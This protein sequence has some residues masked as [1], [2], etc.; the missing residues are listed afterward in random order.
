MISG[1]RA[2]S[3]VFGYE[4]DLLKAAGQVRD[5]NMHFKIYAPFASPQI[6]RISAGG[7]SPIRRFSL[8]GAIAGCFAGFGL[9][10]Y[11][12]LDWPLRTSAKAIASLPAYFV[13]GYECAILLGGTLTLLGIF[14]LCRI[15][16]VLRKIGYDPRFSDDKFGLVIDTPG[17]EVARIRGVL[18]QCGAEEVKI[19]P[20][21]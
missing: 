4:S 3:G 1:R 7:K 20:V 6:A 21:L 18:E 2:V 12:S 13:I 10:V 19:E 16:D 9:A 17:D 15:P 14:H 5:S 11:C 8:L